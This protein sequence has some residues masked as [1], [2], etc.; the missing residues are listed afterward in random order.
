MM[1]VVHRGLVLR[2]AWD[3]F[4]I[5]W[6]F[7]RVD[8]LLGE[9]LDPLASRDPRGDLERALLGLDRDG[10]DLDGRSPGQG[11]DLDGLRARGRADGN[12]ARRLR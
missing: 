5:A 7:S 9:P 12:S 10:V 6:P 1:G 2:R 8:V 3:R 11:R 4:V